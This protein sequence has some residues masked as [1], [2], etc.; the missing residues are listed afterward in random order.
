[1]A[2]KKEKKCKCGDFQ[3]FSVSKAEN[4]YKISA[5]FEQKNKTL[6]QRAGWCPSSCAYKEFVA[7]SKPEMFARL[8]KIMANDC[9]CE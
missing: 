1:M 7:T 9:G 8:E 2:E 4:G 5:C 6:S 3:N